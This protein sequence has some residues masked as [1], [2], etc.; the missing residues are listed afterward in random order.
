MILGGLP[1]LALDRT[2]AALLGAVVLV[3][4]GTMDAGAAWRAIDAPTIALLF[5]TMV[6]SGQ[7]RA[8]GF[9]ARVTERLAA[10]GGSPSR[11]LFEVVLTAGALS[12]LLTNDVACIAIAPVLADVCARRGLDPVPFLLG[13]A[14]GS[15]VGSAATLIGN[16]QNV[17]VG[18]SLD[19]SFAGYLLDG[20]PPAAL[21]LVA[22]WAILARAWRG[23]F[24]REVAL[25]PL[26]HPPFDRAQTAKGLVVLGA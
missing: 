24:E 12:A 23:R 3:A 15:N 18:Q 19:L 10:R 20:V 2:G 7:L 14:A 17:L 21:G 1:G 22:T 8:S 5:G 25:P 16:P 9:Y 4:A 13:L 11:F 26:P 6:V